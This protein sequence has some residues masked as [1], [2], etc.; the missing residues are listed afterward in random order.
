RGAVTNLRQDGAWDVEQGQQLFVPALFVNVE[1]QCT[2]GIGGIGEVAA[3]AGKVPQQ[4]G[5]Y[6]AEGEFAGFCRSACTFNMIE[7]PADLAGRKIRVQ[8]QAGFVLQDVAA[9]FAS[10]TPGDLLT[11]F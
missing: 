11:P 3:A 9:L 6:G 1:Q 5:V 8:Q 7:Y 4:P 2:A 10:Q